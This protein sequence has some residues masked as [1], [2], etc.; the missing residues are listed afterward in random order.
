MS[1]EAA[2]SE[3]MERGKNLFAGFYTS[4]ETMISSMSKIVPTNP[5]PNSNEIEMSDVKEKGKSTQNNRRGST[6]SNAPQLKTTIIDPTD[7]QK[8]AIEE[9]KSL[10]RFGRLDYALQESVLENPYLSS[11]G[12]HMNYWS[13]MDV[14]ALVVRALY[15][16][17]LT[18]KQEP[19]TSP[20]AETAEI[21]SPVE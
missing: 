5:D 4:A 21:A 16:I 20:E 14:N 1:V 8:E 7:Y 2:K 9:L 17:D 11:L 3:I 15:G 19:P 10:N 12:V 13:D 6:A 18:L